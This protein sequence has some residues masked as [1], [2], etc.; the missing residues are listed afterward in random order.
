MVGV[1]AEKIGH[2]NSMNANSMNVSMKLSPCH[3]THVREER[4]DRH[5]WRSVP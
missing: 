3:T 1:R 4:V 5:G 2:L